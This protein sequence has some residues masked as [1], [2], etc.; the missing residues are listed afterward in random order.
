MIKIKI[1][2]KWKRQIFKVMHIASPQKKDSSR[3]YLCHIFFFFFLVYHFPESSLELYELHTIIVSILQVR[4]M[5][6]REVKKVA[7]DHKIVR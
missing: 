7:Q 2:T 4:N 1:N 6:Y 5:R 3:H